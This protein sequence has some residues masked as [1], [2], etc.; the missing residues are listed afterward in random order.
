M[1]LS[2]HL[3]YDGAVAAAARLRGLRR[4]SS[5]MTDTVHVRLNLSNSPENIP[6]VRQALAGF[7]EA[8][9]LP[10]VEMNDIRT[11]LTEA[12]NNASLHAY[13]GGEG[14]MEVE[15][16]AAPNEV[17][18]AVR[19]RGHGLE[20]EG[21]HVELPEP[22]GDE[23]PGIG[24][25]AIYALADRVDVSARHGGGTEVAM[26][27]VAPRIR[28]APEEMARDGVEPPALPAAWLSSTVELD[29]APLALSQ[30]VFP[31]V[32]RAMAARAYFT[33]DRLADAQRIGA[34]LVADAATMC[35][36]H[37]HAGITAT[38]AGVD[39]AVGPLGPGG[40][41]ALAEAVRAVE[42][43]IEDLVDHHLLDVS[44]PGARLGLRLPRRR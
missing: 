36:E 23:L 30:W 17:G 26:S 21:R 44:A 42:P 13:A 31:R 9:E 5:A 34:V 37:V 1:H 8:I 28:L 41:R 3:N 7:G 20:L 12:C 33:I 24:L 19:D 14:P 18:V 27:F 10:R 29:M 11:A 22:S 38:P 16:S 39:V 4:D 40:A 43:D 25:P 6:M 32:M 2:R 35:S 15:L